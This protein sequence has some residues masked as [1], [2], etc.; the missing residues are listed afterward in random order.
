MRD[1]L[2][3]QV[4]PRLRG[5][6]RDRA[7]ERVGHLGRDGRLTAGEPADEVTHRRRH[8]L[9]DREWR[10]ARG[11]GLAQHAR[12]L[13]H[14]RQHRSVRAAQEIVAA[15]LAAIRGRDMR[16]DHLADVREGAAAGRH[17][18][19][20]AVANHRE[21]AR[22][23]AEVV[24]ADDPARLQDHDLESARGRGARDLLRFPFGLLVVDPRGRLRGSSSL[25]S[26]R[27]T[28]ARTL[29]STR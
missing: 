4:A 1:H 11:R 26:L 29:R 25:R 27:R 13:L 3:P 7:A 16:G 12:D 24:R 2:E 22:P 19:Q 15:V 28:P 17:A 10:L 23:R 5:G 6:H 21:H 9:D 8:C 14:E 18:D 20:L